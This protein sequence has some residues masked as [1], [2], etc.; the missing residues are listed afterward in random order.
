MCQV[1]RLDV[2][3]LSNPVDGCC[4]IRYIC[5]P[6]SQDDNIDAAADRLRT[7]DGLGSAGIEIGAVV[8]GDYQYLAHAN[9]RF[10]NSCT[11]CEAFSTMMPFCRCGG[12]A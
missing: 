11:S 9:P 1:I 4:R 2:Q 8:L 12:G 7:A 10:F 3:H 5:R 6:L